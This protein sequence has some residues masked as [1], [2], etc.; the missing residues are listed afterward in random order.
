MNMN[1]LF[2]KNTNII[3]LATRCV[4]ERCERESKGV[5]RRCMSWFT[6]GY[7][8]SAMFHQKLKG[9]TWAQWMISSSR[10]GGDWWAFNSVSSQ[11]DCWQCS[12]N[13]VP[14]SKLS[15]PFVCKEGLF[16]VQPSAD[17]S[18]FAMRGRGGGGN[19]AKLPNPNPKIINTFHTKI[20]LM[21][22]IP[23]SCIFLCNR[24]GKEG[25]MCTSPLKSSPRKS[26]LWFINLDGSPL[27]VSVYFIVLSVY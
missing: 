17:I 5:W 3:H 11:A 19:S 26:L 7:W 10:R 24:G 8:F 20:E 18:G 22:T 9:N 13:T 1:F 27:C 6:P 21:A 15:V 23:G 25:G 2:M 14:C 12:E 4:T 16:G